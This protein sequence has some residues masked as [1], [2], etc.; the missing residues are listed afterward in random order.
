MTPAGPRRTVRAVGDRALLVEC[1]SLQDVMDLHASLRAAPRPG[2]TDVLAAAAT[3]LVRTSGPGASAR[4]ARELRGIDVA[5]TPGAVPPG[6]P[7]AATVARAAVT[8]STVMIDTVTID[9]VYDGEDLA[10]VAELTGLS[11][12]D[13]VARHSSTLWTAA[14]GGFAPGFTYLTAQGT[15]LEVPRR[16]VPRT[17]VP[18]GSVALAG[19]FSAV[20]PQD[21]PG[22]WR[23]IGRTSAPMWHLD[24]AQ[25]A[26]VVPGDTV[27]FRRVRESV[28]A[29][30]PA[31]VEDRAGATSRATTARPVSGALTV[32]APGAQSLVE[33]L[34][35][36]GLLDLGVSPSGA[37]DRGAA[38]R[39]N[40]LVGN[41]RDAAVIETVL[42]GL[43]LQAEGDQVVAVTGA[44]APLAL[45]D[46]DGTGVRTAPFGAPFVM[47]H[48]EVLALGAPPNGLR[49]YVGVRGGVD[50][51]P[52]LGSRSTDLLSGLGPV[53]LRAGT[54]LP[55][56]DPARTTAVGLPDPEVDLP[57]GGV[58]VRVVEGPRADW[59]T[60]VGLERLYAQEWLVTSRSNRVGLRLEGEALRSAATGELPSEGTVTGAV[61]VPPS[62]QPV[63]FLADHPVSGGYPVVAVVRDPDLDRL[64]QLRPGQR[65]RFTR[66]GPRNPP[67]GAPAGA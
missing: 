59:L 23:L 61:Q 57:V 9:T 7:S 55:V 2:Q 51:P 17:H 32:V 39:T 50:V 67:P 10:A 58:T 53:P 35:R 5:A 22:G 6:D 30:R 48:G 14:F 44:P 52:V 29:N 1:T 54:V 13:V 56:G 26:L 66:S 65:L 37:A 20:Y 11:V 15:G 47:R 19:G 36:P 63:V 64:A 49:S 33:D 21:S 27:R 62:G 8:T 60:E 18:A 24:R 40:R 16:P 25:P 42:G 38:A 43:V 3:V 4:L 28:V 12:E 34:G 41:P 45:G 46:A 31:P